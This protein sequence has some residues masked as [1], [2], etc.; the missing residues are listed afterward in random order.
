MREIKGAIEKD[1]KML[2]EKC[3]TDL[4]QAGSVKFVAHMDGRGFY[5]DVYNCESCDSVIEVRNKRQS[6]AYWD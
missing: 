1:G 4:S 3:N 2:C 5:A 6:P